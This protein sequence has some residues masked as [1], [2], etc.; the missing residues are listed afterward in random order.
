MNKGTRTDVSRS[1]MSTLTNQVQ[2]G[3]RGT[4]WLRD[5]NKPD[6]LLRALETC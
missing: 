5:E 3:H 4:P 1:R 2:V 6:F